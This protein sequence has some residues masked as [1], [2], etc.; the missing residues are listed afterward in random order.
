MSASATL[1][2][3]EEGAIK[4]SICCD[5]NLLYV[6][7]VLEKYREMSRPPCHKVSAV[8]HEILA[9]L[10]AMIANG[11]DGTVIKDQDGRP[12]GKVADLSLAASISH[13]RHVVAVA[14]ATRA[15]LTV[16][17]DVE[18]MKPQRA[19]AELATQIA[20]PSS[21]GVRAFYDGWC[22]YEALFKATGVN[23]PERQRDL[24]P[25]TEFDLQTPA[26]F[27]GKLVVGARDPDAGMCLKSH[28]IVSPVRK[29]FAPGR[30]V[31][32]TGL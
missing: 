17:I 1:G 29:V 27:A 12:W 20:M 7:H 32:K 16:G 5:D 4:P 8:A 24:A 6:I 28:S 19:I 21:T 3:G 15:D 9:A 22:R 25:L 31:F 2:M 30:L 10:V 23:D 18:Y 14:L 13:S 11:A 26:G